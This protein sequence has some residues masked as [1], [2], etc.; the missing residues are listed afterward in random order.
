MGTALTP[1]PLR[2][3]ASE[4]PSRVVSGDRA[5]PASGLQRRDHLGLV[6]DLDGEPARGP[7]VE[8]PGPVELPGCR[9]VE[10]PA[11]QPRMDL[12]HLLPALLQE[13]DV[14]RPG[15]F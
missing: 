12:V 3:G 4:A 9:G 7:E 5:S 10:A 13:S 2:D 14:E 15:V 6:Q 11:L 8:R 1:L